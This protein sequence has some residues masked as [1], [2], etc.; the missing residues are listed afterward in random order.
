MLFSMCTSLRIASHHISD[1]R[2][3]SHH[4]LAWHTN[5]TSFLS[6]L[7]LIHVAGENCSNYIEKFRPVPRAH[8]AQCTRVQLIFLSRIDDD[9]F[10]P[11]QFFFYRSLYTIYIVYRKKCAMNLFSPQSSARMQSDQT[12]HDMC[13]TK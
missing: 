2:S 8:S 7:I 13:R 9:L 6:F 4:S 11:F 12:P 3:H 5:K 10:R 1:G